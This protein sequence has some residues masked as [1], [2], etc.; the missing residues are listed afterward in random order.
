MPTL[1]VFIETRTTDSRGRGLA[2]PIT[3]ASIL[4]DGKPFPEFGSAQ[5]EFSVELAD[6]FNRPP[7]WNLR[8][9]GKIEKTDVTEHSKGVLFPNGK[10]HS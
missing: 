10:R 8:S 6:P 3:T 4:Y 7:V 2:Q 1:K 5:F 9:D